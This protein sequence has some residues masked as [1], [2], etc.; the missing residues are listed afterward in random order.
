MPRKRRITENA[1]VISAESGELLDTI[2]AGESIS[3]ETNITDRQKESYLKTLEAALFYN[4]VKQNSREHGG[5]TIL[6]IGKT[7]A[8]LNPATV[9]RLIFLSTFLEFN[10][11]RLIYSKRP[12]LKD[13]LKDVLK[14][15]KTAKNQFFNECEK[16]GIIE[17]HGKEGLFLN[18]LFFRHETKENEWIK[19]YHN[20]IQDLYNRML[21]TVYKGNIIKNLIMDC[22]SYTKYRPNETTG[23]IFVSWRRKEELP[24][25]A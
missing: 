10:S 24:T 5:F 9:G 17:D 3:P 20:T 11:Q 12:M 6:T 4:E 22:Q 13:D 25:G 2:N 14:L 7:L 18:E 23:G 15:G 8:N 21:A 19:L 1:L 16:A